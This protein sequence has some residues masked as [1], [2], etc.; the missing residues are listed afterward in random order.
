[1]TIRELI[2]KLKEL[3]EQDAKVILSIPSLPCISG[4]KIHG[5]L[6]AI[7]PSFYNSQEQDIIL[8]LAP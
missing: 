7:D 2:E 4:L 8:R 1:M 5:E 3:P 6:K